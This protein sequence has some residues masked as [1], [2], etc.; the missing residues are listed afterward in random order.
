MSPRGSS[1]PPSPRVAIRCRISIPRPL[2]GVPRPEASGRV[3]APDEG[4]SGRGPADPPTVRSAPVVP[5]RIGFGLGRVVGSPGPAERPTSC[6]C[7]SP[8]S[9][10]TS[11]SWRRP[12]APAGWARS[13]GP[14]T[15]AR[16]PGRP[17]DPAA[18]A[19]GRPRGRP[20]L[21]PGGPGGG[22]ARPREHRP[23]LHD[24]PRR[25]VP[26]HRLRVHRRDDD[27]PAG[28]GRTGRSPVGDAINYTLQI[29]DAP[30]PRGRARGGPSR[31]QAVEH[32]RHARRGGPSSST[33]AW[34]AGSSGARTPG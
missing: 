31:H 20:A 14:S 21:L 30:G 1:P 32:H 27:P 5:A 29:A 10:W 8:A 16:P 3:P 2:P 18:R 11:S 34:P 4:D 23:G 6:R 17:E 9:G 22:P 25:P 26:L 13:S 24:R 12:S 33:W 28:R 15:P 7:R 19:G